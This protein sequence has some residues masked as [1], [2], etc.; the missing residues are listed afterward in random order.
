MSDIHWRTLHLG[1]GIAQ[2]RQVGADGHGHAWGR[3]NIFVVLQKT[4]FKT[5]ILNKKCLKAL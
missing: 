3:I 5:E 2:G 1:S 4:D